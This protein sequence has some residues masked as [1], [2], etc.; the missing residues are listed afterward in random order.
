MV[1]VEPGLG[2][3]E[4]EPPGAAPQGVWEP[5]RPKERGFSWAQA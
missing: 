3:M 5:G 2:G 4:E 1:R